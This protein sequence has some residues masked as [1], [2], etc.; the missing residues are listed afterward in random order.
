MVENSKGSLFHIRSTTHDGGI[1]GSNY[2]VVSFL[3][4]REPKNLR[5]WASSVSVL[6]N[7]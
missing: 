2:R 3:N 4:V 5:L 1:S 7:F 6:A